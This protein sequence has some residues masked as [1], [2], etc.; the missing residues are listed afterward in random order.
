MRCL[1]MQIS[2]SLII[3]L[4]PKKCIYSEASSR[5][6]SLLNRKTYGVLLILY[7][8]FLYISIVYI[9]YIIIRSA[10]TVAYEKSIACSTAEALEWDES[11]K[12]NT[13][14]SGRAVL[15][16]HIDQVEMKHN[17]KNFQSPANKFV[18]PTKEVK[19]DVKI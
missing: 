18:E 7:G 15:G 5:T 19:E 10:R 11:F 4:L 8:F 16:V 13:D 2:D 9:I 12:K 3:H 14:E 1:L 17:I 6:F